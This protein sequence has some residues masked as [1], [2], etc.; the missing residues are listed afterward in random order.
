M[1]C[2]SAVLRGLQS[3]CCD[4]LLSLVL[5]RLILQPF[6]LCSLLEKSVKGSTHCAVPLLDAINEAA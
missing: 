3:V 4:L 5:C 1:T 6:A 2:C